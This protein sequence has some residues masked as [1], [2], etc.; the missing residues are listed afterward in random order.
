M[1]Q[2]IDLTLLELEKLLRGTRF[3]KMISKFVLL[4]LQLNVML[5]NSLPIERILKEIV[6]VVRGLEEAVNEKLQPALAGVLPSSI[7]LPEVISWSLQISK[8][9]QSENIH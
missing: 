2:E 7:N 5:V 8:Q 6:N 9:K 3:G 1:R 4:Y